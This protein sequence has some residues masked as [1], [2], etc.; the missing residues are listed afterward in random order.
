VQVRHFQSG[1]DQPDA[2]RMEGALLPLPDF[3]GHARTLREQAGID[4]LPVV[5]F[6][7]RHDQGM[8]RPDRRDGQEGDDLVVLP[9][10]PGR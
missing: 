5:H 2:R 3:L 1:D 6:G 8:P 7:A 4:V 10:E 9:H